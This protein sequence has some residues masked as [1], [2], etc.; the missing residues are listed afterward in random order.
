MLIGDP[1]KY[2]QNVAQEIILESDRD[3]ETHKI[4][5]SGYTCQEGALTDDK[6]FSIID[7]AQKGK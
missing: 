6:A 2:T 1:T 5:H 3:I 4:I 7:P